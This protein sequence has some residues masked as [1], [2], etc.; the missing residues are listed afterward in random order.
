MDHTTQID[1]MRQVVGNIALHLSYNH[2]E[3]A[4]KML[5]LLILKAQ[6]LIDEVEDV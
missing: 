5:T 4:T 2:P 3:E 1:E 6:D